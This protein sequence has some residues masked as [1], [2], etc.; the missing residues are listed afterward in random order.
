MS[1]RS[2]LPLLFL[3]LLSSAL[4]MPAVADSGSID[5]KK[6]SGADYKIWIPN[7]TMVQS[8]ELFIIVNYANSD[9][10]V[11]LTGIEDNSTTQANKT[12]F[13]ATIVIRDCSILEIPFP[14]VQT[15]YF[16]SILENNV[17]VFTVI[18]Y[19]PGSYLPPVHDNQ[20][21]ISPPVILQ[22][23]KIYPQSFLDLFAKNLTWELI[24]TA[25]LIA[26]VGSLL[27]VSIKSWSKFLVPWDF[28]SG[29]VY[30]ILITDAWRHWLP[31]LGEF[32]RLWYIPFIIGYW[33]GYIYFHLDYCI[34]ILID[35]KEKTMV[36]DPLVVY[37]EKGKTSWFIQEQSL[38]ALF[39]RMLGVKHELTADG[40]LEADWRTSSKRPYFPRVVT[41]SIWIQRTHTY[42]EEV[43]IWVFTFQ[44]WTTKFSLANASLMPKYLWL[45]SS[46]AFDELTLRLHWSESERVHLR[47][48]Y[49]AESVRS[50][51]D[52]VE[53]SI[54]VAREQ[55]IREYFETPLEPYQ[56]PDLNEHELTVV[57]KVETAPQQ[58]IGEEEGAEEDN[59]RPEEEEAQERPPKGS[60][61][62]NKKGKVKKSNGK[63]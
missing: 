29:A 60:K 58:G 56:E 5:L 15:T 53:H 45:D 48:T 4:V 2:L 28:G 36:L 52:M 9:L 17:P 41:K 55:A 59:S 13:M 32:N 40:S 18:F 6:Y 34:P 16:F 14:D 26:V 8:A 10:F 31:I 20:W 51:A 11:K 39:A 27:G 61:Q 37:Q 3:L 38:K 57:E 25:T 24:I 49:K 62:S 44:K 43:K 47:L 19:R 46:K 12:Y 63:R 1:I 50:A 30:T 23:P 21:T 7:R 42:Q 54:R 33:I 35:S 22:E